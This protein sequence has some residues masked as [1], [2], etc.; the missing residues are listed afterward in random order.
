[1]VVYLYIS[2]IQTV[3]LLLFQQFLFSSRPC[4][5]RVPNHP[6]SRS[7]ITRPFV[8]SIFCGCIELG[9]IHMAL[10]NYVDPF[11]RHRSSSRGQQY[12]S[13]LYPHGSLSAPASS[14]PGII[15]VQIN[16]DIL[17]P[18]QCQLHIHPCTL[19]QETRPPATE[20]LNCVSAISIWNTSG[21]TWCP[22]P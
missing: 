7:M 20:K 19:A 14:F 11:H 3:L 18:K 21:S 22:R 16:R 5:Q 4:S 2:M 6:K 8:F 13:P 17:R 10:Q 1:M 9:G 12:F 15:P